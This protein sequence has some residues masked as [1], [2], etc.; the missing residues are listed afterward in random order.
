M[1]IVCA[2]MIVYLHTGSSTQDEVIGRFLHGVLRNLCR[3]AIPWFFFSSG[4]FLARHIGESG[5]YRNHI[6]K[7]YAKIGCG[8]IWWTIVTSKTRSFYGVAD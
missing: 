1:S 8:G 4:F 2:A 5:W 6:K 3:V 7:N